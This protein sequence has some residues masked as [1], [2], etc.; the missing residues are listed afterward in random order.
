[1]L[2][3]SPI[4]V[5]GDGSTRRDYTYVSDIVDG[6]ISALFYEKTDYEI[7][8]LGNDK[9]ISLSEMIAAIES[10]L[11]KQAIIDRKP[12]QPGDVSQTWADIEKS[13]KF[14]N[15]DPK[16]SFAEG[17][18]SYIAY[19]IVLMQKLKILL[20]TLRSWKPLLRPR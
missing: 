9:T 18:N 2:E 12:E 14:L 19:K 17:L 13:K 1:M 6:I 11:G 16:Y 3:G 4:P 8:N 5:F 10:A 7:F 20:W 15:Y